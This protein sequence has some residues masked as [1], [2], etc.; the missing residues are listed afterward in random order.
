MQNET[1]SLHVAEIQKHRRY[2]HKTINMI[3][4]NY[5]IVILQS[6]FCIAHTHIFILFAMI[7]CTKDTMLH[8]RLLLFWFGRA[9]ALCGVCIQCKAFHVSIFSAFCISNF[10]NRRQCMYTFSMAQCAAYYFDW[11]EKMLLLLLFHRDAVM[12]FCNGAFAPIKWRSLSYLL[13]VERAQY[14]HKVNTLHRV[15]EAEVWH[16]LRIIFVETVCIYLEICTHSHV[17]G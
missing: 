17:Y 6:L 7:S 1:K 13:D 2:C 11:T 16:P 9:C 5:F 15:Y 10:A 3:H 4:G 8:D 12:W 14:I